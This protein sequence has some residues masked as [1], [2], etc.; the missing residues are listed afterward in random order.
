MMIFLTWTDRRSWLPTY[1]KPIA[2]LWARE[3]GSKALAAAQAYAEKRNARGDADLQVHATS[4]YELFAVAK[5]EA[6]AAHKVNHEQ[7]PQG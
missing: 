4:T 2:A 7:L 3:G 1:G 6:L 5:A